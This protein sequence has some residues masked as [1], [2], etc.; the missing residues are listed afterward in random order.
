MLDGNTASRIV[1]LRREI[2]R[3]DEIYFRKAQQG[4]Q[5]E[6]S[7]QD[8]DNLKSELAEL[9]RKHLHRMLIFH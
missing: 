3:Y 5:P 2:E 1:F 8:Y 9:E 7:D 6:I 4:T